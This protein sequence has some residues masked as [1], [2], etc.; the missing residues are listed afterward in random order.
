MTDELTDHVDFEV[1][2]NKI[3][4]IEAKSDTNEDKEL[5]FQSSKQ[6]V[7]QEKIRDKIEKLPNGLREI[8][9]NRFKAEFVSVEKIDDTKLI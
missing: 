9:E 4:S 5:T 8:L 1:T 7:D 6:V 3:N 2:S